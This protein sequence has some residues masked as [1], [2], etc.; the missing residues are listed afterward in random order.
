MFINILKVIN[1]QPYLETDIKRPII[2]K[3]LML[4]LKKY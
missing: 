1:L 3:K 2:Y 4:N